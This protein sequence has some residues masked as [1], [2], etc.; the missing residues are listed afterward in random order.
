MLSDFFVASLFVRIVCRKVFETC[1]RYKQGKCRKMARKLFN[2]PTYLI[3]HHIP[4]RHGNLSSSRPNSCFGID[5]QL[6]TSNIVLKMC[7]L[8]GC[9]T[10]VIQ[11]LI[12]LWCTSTISEITEPVRRCVS[13]S[14]D[15]CYEVILGPCALG[16]YDLGMIR[17]E[18]HLQQG[19]CQFH[20]NSF[21]CAQPATHTRHWS[22]SSW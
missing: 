4:G 21:I 22:I 15:I 7:K 8:S 11:T 16:D 17:E 1:T 20:D 18:I 14:V 13:I 10:H 5:G 9:S 12:Q 6:W 19:N 2:Y 3:M